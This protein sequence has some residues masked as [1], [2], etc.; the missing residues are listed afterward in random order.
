MLSRAGCEQSAAMGDWAPPSLPRPPHAPGRTAALLAEAAPALSLAA[1]PCR[2]VSPLRA[3]E[4]QP[5]LHSHVVYE[6]LHDPQPPYELLHDPQPPRSS[7]CVAHLPLRSRRSVPTARCVP[8][9]NERITPVAVLALCPAAPAR[10][11]IGG[12]Q[13]WGGQRVLI[14]VDLRVPSTQ[15]ITIRR[16]EPR[17]SR[18]PYLWQQRSS[19]PRLPGERIF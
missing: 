10:G 2:A 1:M 3:A 15:E 8:P 19:N 5:T 18:D 14:S 9:P 6:L 12:P 13:R 16:T 4:A 11:F 17:R 7:P